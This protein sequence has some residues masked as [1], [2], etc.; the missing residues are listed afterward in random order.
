M[1]RLSGEVSEKIAAEERARR[2]AVD[3]VLQLVQTNEERNAERQSELAALVHVSQTAVEER[4]EAQLSLV[5]LEHTTLLQDLQQQ[6][7]ETTA[8][9]QTS[10][11]S[12]I[13]SLAALQTQ[14]DALR[15]EL[16][17]STLRADRLETTVAAQAQLLAAHAQAAI[18]ARLATEQ[19][20]AALEEAFERKLSVVSD[21]CKVRRQC[22]HG[23]FSVRFFFFS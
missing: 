18:E 23:R 21:T 13:A 7:C 4:F 22:C 8:A 15:A 12:V 9:T 16:A 1:A 14:H 11:E 2:A 5:R 10:I 19:R 6:M 17:Q 3:R 20:C